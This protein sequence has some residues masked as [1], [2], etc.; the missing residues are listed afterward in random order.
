[1]IKPE[2]LRIALGLMDVEVNDHFCDL[3]LQTI[4]LI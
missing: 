2:Y 3:L 1:M 4:N